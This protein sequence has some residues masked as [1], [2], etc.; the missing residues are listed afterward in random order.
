MSL[1]V[2]LPRFL[3]LGALAALLLMGGSAAAQSTGSRVLLL[4]VNGPLTPPL[5]GYLERG[6]SEAQAQNASL[7]IVRL[8]TPGGQIDLMEKMVAAIRNSP[9]PVVVYVAPRGAIAG[10]AGTL[11]TLAGHVSAMAPETA[12]GAASPVGGQGEELG[13]TVEA[14]AKEALKAQVRALAEKRGPNA[15]ALAE[16]TVQDAKAATA[17]EA[18]AV[19]LIDLIA[20]D[21]PDLLEQLDGRTVE[22]NGQPRTLLTRN[23]SVVELPMSPLEYVL[24]LLVNPNLVFVLLALG[25]QAIIIELWTPGGW[26]AGFFGA[27]CLTLGLYGLGLMPVNWVGIIFILI[28]AVLFVLDINASSHGALTVAGA[29]SLAVGA[30]VLFNSPG[31]LPFFQVSVPLVIATV[32]GLAGLTLAVMVFAL[33]TIRRPAPTL[34]QTLVGQVGEMR[35]ADSALVGSELWSVESEDGT[36]NPGDKVEVIAVKG[37]KLRVKRKS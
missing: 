28:A 21:V 3:A 14:K 36:L 35:S 20:N 4:D 19:N 12:I 5:L 22:V 27:V 17:G 26:V 37:L 8:N 7:V 13:E 23:L 34:A 15:I 29:I 11:I 2:L 9:T 30:L 24:N 1:R 6:L 25:T 16:A 31:S 18:L 32:A 10:S 33:R